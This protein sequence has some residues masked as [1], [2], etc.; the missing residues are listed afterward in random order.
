MSDKA[1]L[2]VAF[3]W[4]M[5]QPYY[6]DPL[7]RVALMPWVRLHA[8]KGYLDM[9]DMARAIPEVRMSFNFTPVLLRQLLEFSRGEVR[10]LWGEW[11]RKPAEDLS[12]EERRQVLEN[13]FKINH[14]TLVDPFPRYRQ[15][16]EKR[17]REGTARQLKSAVNVFTVE[18][19]RDLQTWY[20][21]A[22]CGFSAFRRYPELDELRQKGRDFSEQEKNRVLDIHLEILQ[23]LPGIYREAAESGQVEIT[24]TP[25]FHPIMPLVY[26]TDF[27]KR[28]MPGRDF[29]ERFS[30]PEDVKS[31]LRLAQEQHE[32][33]F[34]SP[35]RGLWPSE[36][37][38]APELIPLF[39]EAGIEYFCT[40]EDNLFRSLAA[41]PGLKGKKVDHLEL[42][43]PWNCEFE[44]SSVGAV[45]RER[46][47]SDF[48]GFNAARNSASDAAGY[49]AHHLEHLADVVPHEQPV[50]TLALDGENAWEAFPDGGE[51]FLR[52]T[53]EMLAQ[54][55]KLE[56]AR[57]GE[58]FDASSPEKRPVVKTLHTGSWISANFDIW[59]GDAE[60]NAG[61]ERIREARA[62]LVKK[63]EVGGI[64]PDVLAQAW[65]AIYAAEGSDW[66]WWYGPDFQTDCDFLFDLLFRKHL[67]RVYLLLGEDPPPILEIPIQQEQEEPSA[68]P[69]RDLVA[70]EVGG[71]L[72]GFYEWMGAGHFD[73]SQQQTAMFQSDRRVRGLYY[74]FDLSRLFFRVDFLTDFHGEVLFKFSRPE[75]VL[76]KVVSV[77]DGSVRMELSRGTSGRS[78]SLSLPDGEVAWGARMEWS[79][80]FEALG[81]TVPIEAVALHIEVIEE[82]LEV[83]RYPERGVLDFE[84]PSEAF[85]LKNW[86]V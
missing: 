5:H 71:D 67:Q 52:K 23:S 64:E 22:W 54:S 48:I 34:G 65:D 49:L 61:W 66:F 58:I 80:S 84:G 75:P 57:L 29:P 74:G 25:F 30:A 33:V 3:L 82:G 83:E 15:L 76:V 26:D 59:I 21:L 69:P 68:L 53:Y 16:I 10:D 35:A 32:E 79:V 81:W 9:I 37:S 50:V 14:H 18:D 47:L 28:A 86:F 63:M 4:H 41:D 19:L 1:P 12:A 36:G 24:T 20:N 38:V 78:K 62:F 2:K 39:A 7:E 6:V 60:E 44:G 43:Q 51:G 73:T 46:P 40:D 56:S 72:E 42:F 70:P 13:F 45:F 85:Q 17:G 11:S 27:G 31:H 55:D 77:R 8:V